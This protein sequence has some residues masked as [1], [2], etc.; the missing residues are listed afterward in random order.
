MGKYGDLI[1][2]AKANQPKSTEDDP[3]V[4]L[5][6]KVPRSYRQHW[7]VESKRNGSSV[8]QDV[9]KA[10]TELYGLPE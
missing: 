4:S 7:Q 9:I 8:T 3:I 6:I 10:L 5:T 1:K 2:G